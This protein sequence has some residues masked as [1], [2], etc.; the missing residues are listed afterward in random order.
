MSASR[1]RFLLRHPLCLLLILWL[2]LGCEQTSQLH[3]IQ[4]QQILH[5]ALLHPPA[6]QQLHNQPGFE[7]ELI[8]SFADTLGLSIQWHPVA[9][10]DQITTLLRQARVHLAIGLLRTP[11]NQLYLRFSDSYRTAHLRL[12]Y[13]YGAP[14]PRSLTKLPDTLYVAE[15]S[16][17]P[18]T[19]LTAQYPQLHTRIWPATEDSNLFAALNQ[20]HVL[21][22]L[23][24]ADALA[25][26]QPVYPYLMPGPDVG[27]P[28]PLA[29]AF[30]AQDD[31]SLRQAANQFLHRWQT[32]GTLAHLTERYYGHLNRFGF[33][34]KQRFRRHLRERFPRYRAWFQQAAQQTG[35]DWRIL[36]AMGYQE[37]H[38]RANAV[39]PTGVRGLMMLTHPTAR[40]L[41]IR[42]RTDPQ[43]SILGGARYLQ[44]LMR[45]LP[46][47]ISGEDR[48]WFA[49]AS[50]NVGLGHVEDA[51]VL[52]ERQGGNPN[53]W[54]QVKQRLP[55]LRQKRF[56]RTLKYGYA[57]GDEPVTYVDNIRYYYD[58]LTWYEQHP[59]ALAKTSE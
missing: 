54:H 5:V 58:M 2:T 52:T 12:A 38:W 51:R 15:T 29:W 24:H 11:A 4:Q 35:L 37:S 46:E 41:G 1:R 22:A 27:K 34:D 28:Q 23:A 33:V 7:Q 48:L 57:R 17:I 6:Y 59:K 55:L 10:P 31:D 21:Y 19:R 42:D 40:Q 3:R 8:Q 32:N 45:R 44:S 26:A 30:P 53:L 20:G 14:K 50:Y 25:L 9:T 49:I 36:A 56:Y 16:G 18:L 43:Q 39:S 13:R 47:R